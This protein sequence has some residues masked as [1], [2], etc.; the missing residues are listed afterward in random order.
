MNFFETKLE[1]QARLQHLSPE[2]IKLQTISKMQ[3][4]PEEGEHFEIRGG[5]GNAIRKELKREDGIIY[6]RDNPK[7]EWNKYD[8]GAAL[9]RMLNMCVKPLKMEE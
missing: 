4:F 1:R 9:N 8:M 2:H 6:E 3:L 7:C 5:Y